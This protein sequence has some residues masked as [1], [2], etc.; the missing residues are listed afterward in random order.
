MCVYRIEKNESFTIYN[1]RWIGKLGNR[2]FSQ[3][4]S[5][6]YLVSTIY[7]SKHGGGPGPG[8]PLFLLPGLIPSLLTPCMTTPNVSFYLYATALLKELVGSDYTRIRKES[9]KPIIVME[10]PNNH[11]ALG[12]GLASFSFSLVQGFLSSRNTTRK[13]STT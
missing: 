6:E 8:P 12:S 2:R 11:H 5:I 7:P 4:S 10:R 1:A 3:K 13:A 9:T